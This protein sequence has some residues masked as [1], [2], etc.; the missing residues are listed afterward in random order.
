MIDRRPF[1]RA[2]DSSTVT[3]AGA[4]LARGSHAGA[5]RFLRRAGDLNLL[6]RVLDAVS[7]F[8][9]RRPCALAVPAAAGLGT[10]IGRAIH[11]DT[12]VAGRRPHMSA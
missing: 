6:P 10:S 1:E 8:E 2:N 11:R 5:H 4:T 9:R 3:L 7:R 12:S